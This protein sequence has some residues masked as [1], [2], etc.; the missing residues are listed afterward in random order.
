MWETVAISQFQNSNYKGYAYKKLIATDNAGNVVVTST[1]YNNVNFY[2]VTAKVSKDGSLLWTKTYNSGT[3]DIAHAVAVDQNDNIIVAGRTTKNGQNSDFLIIKY[4]KNGNQLWLST[5]NGG[6]GDQLWDL[7]VDNGNIYVTGSSTK[8]VAS[9]ATSVATVAKFSSS[10]VLMWSAQYSNS[11]FGSSAWE[12]KVDKSGN[13]FIS[14]NSTDQINASTFRP[15]HYSYFIAKYNSQGAQLWQKNWGNYLMP[16]TNTVAHLEVDNSGNSYLTGVVVQTSLNWDIGIWKFDSGGTQKLVTVDHFWDFDFPSGI[17]AD[18]LGNFF[19]ASSSNKISTGAWNYRILKFDGTGALLW[20]GAYSSSDDTPSQLIRNG[21]SIIIAGSKVNNPKSGLVLKYSDPTLFTLFTSDAHGAK[22]SDVLVPIQTS[23]FNNI[24]GNQFSVNW[25]PSVVTFVDVESFGL[26]GLDVSSFG[27]T[28]ANVGQLTMSWSD[29]SLTGKTLADG[30]AIVALRFKLTGNYGDITNITIDGNPLPIEVIDNNFN[31]VNVTTSSG[32]L[33][34][35]TDLTITGRVVYPNDQGVQ[36]VT[37]TLN[38][39]TPQSTSTNSSGS[40][41]LTGPAGVN[42]TITPVKTN[43]PN[44]INGIDVQDVASLRRHLLGVQPLN[45]PYE[46]IAADVNNSATVSTLDII[47]IQALILGI[48]TSFPGNRQWAFVPSD[49]FFT[50]SANPFP[51]DQSVSLTQV[52]GQINQDFIGIKL[53]DVNDSRD[54]TQQGRIGAGNGITF[55]IDKETGTSN[56]IEI[57]IRVRDFNNI[58]A[59]QFTVSWDMNKLEYIDVLSKN[60]EGS[61]GTK[62]TQNGI[63][64]TVWDDL[65]G[66]SKSLNSNDNL[67]VIQFRKIDETAGYKDIDITGRATSIAVY[68]KDL[69]TVPYHVEWGEE[70]L[71]EFELYQNYPNSFS[72]KTEISFNLPQSGKVRFEIMDELGRVIRVIESTY[73]AGKNN[74]EWNGSNND[75]AEVKAGLYFL[76]AHFENVKQTKKMIKVN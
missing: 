56:I 37:V 67:F 69:K 16:M 38:S 29:P 41:V 57:P 19:V 72:K 23:A 54:N 7:V 27:T 8:F 14:G 50:D 64:T 26:N 76:N 13:V 66:Q 45:G 47:Y 24:V 3:A 51:Y 40:Y 17:V 31:N 59:Y 58:S 39:L 68:D 15:D 44:P 71:A 73:P 46:I 20:N 1:V 70:H 60:T 34:I 12:V 4:D 28:N 18:N 52:D 11:W 35:D 9:G 49:F 36:N 5:Y 25:D 75:G 30:G 22:N 6:S 32:K 21:Q 2:C 43:D 48:N 61:F 10:G 63:L 42:Y 53:G 62:N 74:I 55:V 33:T 65:N